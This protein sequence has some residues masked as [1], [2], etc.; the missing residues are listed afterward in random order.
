MRKYT[1]YYWIEKSDECFDCQI[2]IEAKDI[3]I[4]LAEFRSEVRVFKRVFKIEEKTN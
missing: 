3:F 4:A 1:I 2:E